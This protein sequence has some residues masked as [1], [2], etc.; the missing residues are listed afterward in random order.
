MGTGS[1]SSLWIGQAKENTGGGHNLGVTRQTH[2]TLNTLPGAISSV[3]SHL[4]DSPTSA[5]E[6]T[7]SRLRRHQQGG[8]GRL[9]GQGGQRRM[10]P[11]SCS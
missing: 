4:Q 3:V 1:V 5:D 6:S 11:C 10:F 2:H 7:D 9:S 8:R